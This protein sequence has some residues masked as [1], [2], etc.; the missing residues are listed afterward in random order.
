MTHLPTWVPGFATKLF[1][2][3]FPK[4][5]HL[6]IEIRQVCFDVVL[7]SLTADLSD[8]TFELYL[9]LDV[10][11]VNTKEVPTT[12]KEWKLTLSG[13]GKTLQA[14]HLTDIS[15]WHQHIKFREKEHSLGFLREV[16][17]DIRNNLDSFPAEPLHHGI[18]AE[19]WVCFLAHEVNEALK[20]DASIELS[21]VDSFG[22]THR[23]KSHGPR[24]CKGDMVNPD[25]PF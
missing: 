3:F 15:K 11:A 19:G 25:L 7:E 8:Y 14:S 13:A 12:I 1:E 24:P 5:P 18:A 22:K 17:R 21:V 16:I 9:F 20:K 2:L 6:S 4:R 23:L 10:W